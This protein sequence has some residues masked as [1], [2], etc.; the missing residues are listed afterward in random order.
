M[1]VRP[2]VSSLN[3]KEKMKKINRDSYT[4]RL[5]FL[6]ALPNKSS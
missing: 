4:K 6:M 5:I 2:N 1:I 3:M